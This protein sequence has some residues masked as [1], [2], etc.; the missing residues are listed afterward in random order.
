MNT[1]QH[2]QSAHTKPAFFHHNRLAYFEGDAKQHAE[3]IGY[4]MQVDNPSYLGTRL[5]RVVDS[6]VGNDDGG[7]LGDALRNT[8]KGIERVVTGLWGTNYKNASQLI[9]DA[10]TVAKTPFKLGEGVIKEGVNFSWGTVAR[11]GLEVREKVSKV[12]SLDGT[13]VY[14]FAPKKIMQSI[15]AAISPITGAAKGVRNYTMGMSEAEQGKMNKYTWKYNGQEVNKN[16][17]SRLGG[18]AM[19]KEYGEGGAVGYGINGIYSAT[20][21]TLHRAF[22]DTPSEILNIAADTTGQTVTVAGQTVGVGMQVPGLVPV[23]GAASVFNPASWDP[24]TYVDAPPSQ[25]DLQL[26]KE[27]AALKKQIAELQQQ[28][29]TQ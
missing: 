28:G 25:Y 5:N 27:N 22:I 8:G 2:T 26:A 9:T 17:F 11:T 6:V 3:A 21:D 4:E 7:Q 14:N 20:R 16:M 13:T 15:S 1:H 10:K 18:V 12:F 29:N 19:G 24:E 23:I